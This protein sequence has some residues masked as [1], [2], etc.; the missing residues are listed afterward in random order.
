MSSFYRLL[1]LSV[2]IK[3]PALQNKSNGGAKTISCIQ[4]F[5][6]TFSASFANI[7][8]SFIR[9]GLLPIKM[10]MIYIMNRDLKPY[11]PLKRTFQAF[12]TAAFRLRLQFDLLLFTVL[13][14]VSFSW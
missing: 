3:A 13:Y 2:K 11:F 14:D 12:S 9:V 8:S 5:E 6:Q 10:T 4:K 1:L 7:E